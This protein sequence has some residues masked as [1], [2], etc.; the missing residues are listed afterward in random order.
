MDAALSQESDPTT[1]EPRQRR[2]EVVTVPAKT[3]GR[4]QRVG[5]RLATWLF[6]S[7]LTW[8]MHWAIRVEGT[9]FELH[10][11]GG[12]TKPCLRTS[13]WS[14][15]R[16]REIIATVPI[17]STTL[18]D[19]EIVG[20]SMGLLPRSWLCHT[21]LCPVLIDTVTRRALLHRED[22]SHVVQPVH[23]QLPTVCP[24]RARKDLAGA[25]SNRASPNGFAGNNQL[26][27]G[28]GGPSAHPPTHSLVHAM[29]SV[30]RMRQEESSS[31]RRTLLLRYG[32]HRADDGHPPY[33]KLQPSA[34]GFRKPT[35]TSRSFR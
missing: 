10:R 5:L 19:E 18:S 33:P 6:G 15:E 23:Q 27:V 1:A 2:V 20:L 31:L 21:R 9:Y 32:A 17:G 12:V 22:P 4:V 8:A 13:T 25:G 11:P 26:G 3:I 35:T 28:N 30:A 14:E 24:L 34:I 16:Q 29:A 7:P